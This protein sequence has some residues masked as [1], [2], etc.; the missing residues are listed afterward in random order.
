[1]NAVYY[2]WAYF[3][4]VTGYYALVKASSIRAAARAL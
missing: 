2:A 1:M 4:H 3:R